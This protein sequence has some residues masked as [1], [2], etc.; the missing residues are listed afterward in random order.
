MLI[1]TDQPAISQIANKQTAHLH[2]AVPDHVRIAAQLGGARSAINP[3]NL[4]AASPESLESGTP[5][6]LA[7]DGH[8]LASPGHHSHSG[9]GQAVSGRV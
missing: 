6:G 3:F 5:H 9:H 8:R 1:A 2:H 7:A 4:A